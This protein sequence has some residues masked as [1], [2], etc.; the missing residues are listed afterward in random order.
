MEK[1]AFGCGVIVAAVVL[2]MGF[3]LYFGMADDGGADSQQVDQP[4]IDVD[5]DRSK[6]RPKM[7]PPKI[8]TVKPP[9]NR[10]GTSKRR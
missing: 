10:G 2:F 3:A 5:I 9:A 4:G 1:F 8:S 7:S 6:P